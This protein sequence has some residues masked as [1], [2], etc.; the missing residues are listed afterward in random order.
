MKISDEQMEFWTGVFA[1]FLMGAIV[2]KFLPATWVEPT[3][4][5]FLASCV[6][7]MVVWKWYVAR[8]YTAFSDL[9][10]A[11]C[12]PEDTSAVARFDLKSESSERDSD[13][14]R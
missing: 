13:Q 3:Q 5:V 1:Y 12:N 4:K 10:E 6:P 11:G 7:F 8:L 9:P 2:S 14:L